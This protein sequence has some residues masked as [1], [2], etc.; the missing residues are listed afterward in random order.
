VATESPAQSLVQDL[1]RTDSRDAL[2]ARLLPV[3]AELPPDEA[4]N[5]LMDILWVWQ[6]DR[7]QLTARLR[8]LITERYGSKS[9]KSTLDQLML[10]SNVL[11][12]LSDDQKPT[13]QA[14]D[15]SEEGTTSS[16]LDALAQQT[17]DEIDA[18]KK[19]RAEE[20]AAARKAAQEERD[21]Q[22]RDGTGN[23]GAWPE[24]LPIREVVLDPPAHLR[25]CDDP[26]CDR[27]RVVV[28]YETSW[29]LARDITN[30]VLLHKIPVLACASHHGGPV[31]AE[32]PP[33]PVKGGRIGFS[34]AAHILY[35]RITQNL[36]T[37]R[38]VEM[39]AS[40]GMPVTESM[41]HTLIRHAGT[42][43]DPLDKA[44]RRKVQ[45]AARIN[46]DDTPV[47]VHVG[48][49][50]RQRTTGRVWLALGDE[51]FAYFFSTKTWKT[52]E[53]AKALGTIHGVLQGDGYAG[54]AGY[55]RTQQVKLAGCMDHLRR[56][57]TKALKAGD[58][59]AQ[60]PLALING[61]YA[62]ERL[63]VLLD[64]TPEQLLEL[65]QHR[66]A[67]FWEALLEWHARVHLDIVSG[68]LLGKAWTYLKNQRDKLEVYLDDPV[69]SIHNAPAERG[70]R[71]IT[72]GR[73][74][75]L[76][77]RGHDSLRNVTRIL[78]VM[79]TARMHGV[80]EKAYIEWVLRRLAERA[81][82]EE[83]AVALL[84]DAFAA[85]Q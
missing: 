82:S 32:V 65:R 4:M 57:L 27:E 40:E 37:R 63:A 17:Q 22:K 80:N 42:A 1:N 8:H 58:P 31:Q 46:L 47:A 23:P 9:E 36:P 51:Q 44:L 62:I 83:A 10:F 52:E 6:A 67:P 59:R 35:L 76:F 48:H 2:R 3:L 30:F 56:K 81:W 14:K 29:V 28:R 45:H 7:N 12:V 15:D 21:R 49:S 5:L 85:A 11:K 26:D 64:A 25:C 19:K 70:L 74:L 60:E 20:K 84:P 55:A 38:I 18:L 24:H 69:V 77:H 43:L 73:Q 54:F 50:P 71:R 33:K 53:A 72:I 78:S 34:L 68:E 61:L 41:V 66:A 13:R 79:A 16:E 39:L 75:W